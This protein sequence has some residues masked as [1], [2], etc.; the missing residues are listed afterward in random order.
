MK[1]AIRSKVYCCLANVYWVIS[2][3]WC[4]VIV[5]CC[6]GKLCGDLSVFENGP[7]RILQFQKWKEVC[8][9]EHVCMYVHACAHV[10]KICPYIL[11][12][13]WRDIVF[14]LVGK[15]IFMIIIGYFWNFWRTA[16]PRKCPVLHLSMSL[17]PWHMITYPSKP[18]WCYYFKKT[19]TFLVHTKLVHCEHHACLPP[20]PTASV[21]GEEGNSPLIL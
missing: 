17:D 4:Q 3:T 9:C 21:I 5:M 14:P 11:I 12:I 8:V 18:I 20:P 1:P 15:F 7:L 19:Q 10:L 13:W 6:S 16:S 2:K